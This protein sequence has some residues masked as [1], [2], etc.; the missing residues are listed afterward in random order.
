VSTKPFPA[1]W[2]HGPHPFDTTFDTNAGQIPGQ[3]AAATLS[4]ASF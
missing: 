4:L 3:R 1:F 2:C